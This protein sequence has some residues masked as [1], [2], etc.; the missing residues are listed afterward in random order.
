MLV[1]PH[2]SSEL[3]VP[4][5]LLR[6]DGHVAWGGEDQQDWPERVGECFDPPPTSLDQQHPRLLL[7]K[8]GPGTGKTM[9]ALHRVAS[10]L[11]T[12]L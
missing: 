6:P 5:V 3:D 12:R 8:G 9:V 1:L 2:E 7:I 4:A 11:S 10:L